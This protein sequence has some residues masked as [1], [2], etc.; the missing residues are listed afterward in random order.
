MDLS[1]KVLGNRYELTELIGVGG[2]AT[3][4]KAR[5]H[6]LNR[7]V[8][9]KILKDEF[10][11]DSEFIKR[12][13][14]EAQSAASLSHPNIVSIYD[15]GNEGDL[16]YIVME[17]IDGETLK[18][19]IKRRGKLPWKEAVNIA[20]QISAG[21]AKAHANHIVHRDIKP[22]NIII[23]KDGVAKVTDFG[24]AK[25]VSSST[26]NAL[27]STLG[28]VHYFSPEHARGG[29]TDEKSDIYSLGVVMYEMVTGKLPFDADTPVSV[30]LK[31]IEE[32][33]REPIEINGDIPYGVNNIIM[34][35]MSKDV[36]KRYQSASEMHRDLENI[37]KNPTDTSSEATIRIGPKDEFPT[38]KIPI[39]GAQNDK[40][41]KEEIEE[42]NVKKGLTKEQAVTRLFLIIG[43]VVILFVGAVYAGKYIVNTLFGTSKTVE[44]PN[45]I[46]DE[47]EEA[48]R[49]LEKLGL[50]MEIT[51]TKED[52]DMP[53]GYVIE[54]N[55]DEGYQLKEGATVGVTISKG[56]KTVL[57]PDVTN[58][59]VDVAKIQ[60][61]QRGL[62]FAREDKYDKETPSGEII[63]QDPKLNTEV[64]AGSTVTVYVSKGMES[65]LVKVPSVKGYLEEKATEEISR[66]QLI[67]EVT[68]VSNPSQ[69][70]GIVIAQSPEEGEIVS[71]L[72][73]VVL[74]VNKVDDKDDEND[75]N[76]ENKNDNKND[77]KNNGDDKND[78]NSGTNI[79]KRSIKINLSNLGE[80][81][82]FELKVVLQGTLV[83]NRV[84][85]EGTHSRSEG[86]INI[87]ITDAPGSKLT[88]YVDGKIA[89][90]QVLE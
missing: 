4:Y 74:T 53:A 46:G 43:L 85:Y 40:E 15:V 38:Q 26:I 10:A 11:N 41:Y 63:D 87:D 27:G 89:S 42:R 33:P 61:E 60:I 47:Q 9:I 7:D 29:Y 17:L 14:I 58:V 78:K 83:G 68:Y 35:A 84:E 45:L 28:S 31:H 57:V 1:G 22:H 56:D 25:A 54:Q 73:T 32:E 8:A 52:A 3:V 67:A 76:D 62:V 75:S 55:Y 12:F 34:K 48:K 20:S 18:E 51:S 2:M 69:A 24:I 36:S 64:T 13:Q 88:I 5:C 66:A 6:L 82:T 50:V 19:V 21:L 90:E 70:D 23:T 59:S 44:V 49:K 65:G 77:D 79:G 30:A 72:T 71:E 16:H 37:L 86:S 81:E 39:V 80:R